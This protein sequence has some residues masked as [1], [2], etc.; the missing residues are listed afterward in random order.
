MV[1]SQTS[2]R[3]GNVDPAVITY[4]AGVL[5]AQ[6]STPGVRRLRAWAHDALAVRAGER[7]LEIGCGTGSE[8]QV[9]AAAAGGDGEAV[10]LD[11]NEEML[12]LASDRARTAGSAARFVPG[13]VHAIPFADASFDAVLCERVFQ[14]LT[15]P[16]A[17]VTEIARVV[18]PGG[19][20]VLV[21]TDWATSILHPGDP[22]TVAAML[23]GMVTRSAD[24]AAG[25]KLAGWL[26]GAGLTVAD[27]GSQALISE[28]ESVRDTMLPMLI[29][30]A[31]GTGE[32]SQEQGHR[33][34]ADLAEGA[35]R[36]DFHMSVTMFGVLARR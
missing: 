7:V 17:A 34:L 25:R 18:R 2:F 32:I 20:V 8:V 26:S 15:D 22:E 5:D 30:N 3:S 16:V 35:A 11:R 12:A 4:L 19:R 1:D 27:H 36:G 31:T 29:E 13:D 14:H 33:L 28:Y 6:A 23:R 10:G 24:A 9:L 21:D